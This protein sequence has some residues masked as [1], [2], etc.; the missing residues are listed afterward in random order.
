MCESI[1]IPCLTCGGAGSIE[2]YDGDEFDPLSGNFIEG[3]LEYKRCTCVAC[4]GTG[5]FLEA[6]KK[7]SVQESAFASKLRAALLTQPHP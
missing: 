4:N 7:M 6:L 1:Q 3:S 2:H 5:S